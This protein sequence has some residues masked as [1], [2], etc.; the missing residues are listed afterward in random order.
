VRRRMRKRI[1]EEDEGCQDKARQV[2]DEG[3]RG[4]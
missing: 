3:R 1:D 4:G 2:K